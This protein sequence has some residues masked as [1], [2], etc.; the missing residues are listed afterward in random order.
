MRRGEGG[1]HQLVEPVCPICG[2]GRLVAG[3]GTADLQEQHPQRPHVRRHRRAGE[4]GRVW[5]GEGFGWLR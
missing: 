2:G 1:S 4:V 3:V 5:G